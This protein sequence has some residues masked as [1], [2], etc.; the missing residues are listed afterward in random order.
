LSL[1]QQDGCKLRCYDS[2]QV[3]TVWPIYKPLIESALDRGSIYTIDDILEGLCSSAMQLWTWG[4]DA[5][6]VTTIQ[7]DGKT[8]WC[9]LLA[10]GGTNMATWKGYLPVV[11]DWAKTKG[12]E[13]LRVYGR[14]GSEE[15]N[16]YNEY[17]TTGVFTGTVDHC[18]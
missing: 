10:L 7:S 12:C 4:E 14:P 6:L 15:C 16:K 2:Q 1:V 13:E 17:G 8:R 11:D 18:R 5:A 9:L 3:Y